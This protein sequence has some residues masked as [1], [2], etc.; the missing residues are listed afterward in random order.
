[1]LHILIFGSP[2]RK[3]GFEKP[4]EARSLADGLS[5]LA[6]GARAK[7]IRCSFRNPGRVIASELE[8]CDAIVL[9]PNGGM[10][11]DFYANREAPPAVLLL[12]HAPTRDMNTSETLI[13]EFVIC[14]DASTPSDENTW[15]ADQLASGTIWDT[16]CPQIA[17][18]TIAAAR[19]GTSETEGKLRGRLGRANRTIGEL[20]GRLET[21]EVANQSAER[22]LTEARAALKKSTEE[23]NDARDGELAAEQAVEINAGISEALDVAKGDVSLLHATN[24]DLIAEL[25]A[26]KESLAA[27]KE[28]SGRLQAITDEEMMIKARAEDKQKKKQHPASSKKK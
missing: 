3:H 19:E 27:E 26:L 13:P 11:N 24:Q 5:V 22:E 21:A 6:Q 17:A 18:A 10:V 14:M 28:F 8:P 16:L 20:R 9:L 7:D 25:S 2:S 23:C 1:M 15:T 4:D 12:Q